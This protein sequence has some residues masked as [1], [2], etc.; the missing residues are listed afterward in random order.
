MKV[1]KI[2]L[3]LVF[4]ITIAAS[5][6]PLINAD[7]N[8]PADWN[9]KLFE[10][11]S[12][13]I[14]KA[15]D[16]KV[17]GMPCGGLFAG[18][19]Y[20]R[21]DG[22]LAYWWIANDAANTAWSNYKKA[23]HPLGTYEH[24]YGTYEPFSPIDQG[25]AIA[26]TSDH[27]KRNVYQLNHDGFDDIDFIA[28][29][30]IAKVMYK[31]K[32]DDLPCKIDCSIY[33]PFI[34]LNAKDSAIPVTL[35]N[36][37]LQNTSSEKIKIDL[38]GFLEN[39]VM[40]GLKTKIQ[41]K[42]RN[43]AISQD[44]LTSV[45]YDY[46]ESDIIAKDF[47]L[48]DGFEGWQIDADKW[49]IQGDCFTKPQRHQSPG[50]GTVSSFE[51]DFFIS[52][53]TG[54]EKYTGTM[55]SKE[56]TI[57]SDY[58]TFLIGGGKSD[59]L[60]IKLLVNGKAV[61]NSTGKKREYLHPDCWDVKQLKGKKARLVI[62]DNSSK[63]WGHINID[64][65]G[66]CNM[67]YDNFGNMDKTHPQ[68]GNMA[69]TCMDDDAI[70]IPA[71]KNID[72]LLELLRTDKIN[73]TNKKA[74]HM[75]G[76][77]SVGAVVS[78][79]ELTAGKTRELTFAISWYFPNRQQKIF[80]SAPGQLVGF[81]KPVGNMYRNF[82]KDSFDVASYVSKNYKRLSTDTFLFHDTYYN[83]T[84]LPRWFVDRIAMPVSTL[85]T[86]T[87][88]WWANGR[89]WAWEGVASCPGVCTHVWN[90]QHA[91][92]RL[93]PSVQRSVRK[94]QD[95]GCSLKD[96]GLIGDRGQVGGDNPENWAL[97][98]DGQAGTIMKAYR[99]HL[100]TEDNEFL[101]DLWPG[102]KLAMNYLIDGY[103]KTETSKPDGV[104]QGRQPNT[105]DRAI[106]GANTF[107][108]SYYLGALKAAMKMAEIVG[109]N[110]Y[111]N[112]LL[113]IY[114][115]GSRKTTQMLWN[116]QYFI[117]DVDLQKHKREQYGTGCLADQLI[118]QNWA[119]QVNLGYL[120]PTDKVR[121]TLKSIWNYNW[122]PNVGAYNKV[123]PARRIFAQGDEPGMFL[124]TWPLGN[125]P[126]K[127]VIYSEEIWTGS[128]YQVASHMIYEGMTK[129]GLSIIKG[130][131]QRYDGVKHNPF[132]EIEC[133]DH[134]SRAMASWGA[135]I[136]AERFIYDGPKATIGFDP[137]LMADD[138]N[139]FFSAAKGW[140]SLVQK[141]NSKHQTNS[142]ILKWG[143]LKCKK[144][145]FG[146]PETKLD[147]K[148]KVTIN[149]KE[150]KTD[151]TLQ[152]KKLTIVLPEQI[153]LKPG[154]ILK[155]EIVF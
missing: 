84:T 41:G 62:F 32:A 149:S 76:D 63:G 83:K 96:T 25:F 116:G 26:I 90:Y 108:G 106:Y 14:Y 54:R 132:N 124:I 91:L 67:P 87:C 109:D 94:M 153:T 52:S 6:K 71:V 135:L 39:A 18:Q 142:I 24:A 38:A 5:A 107:T 58:I 144:L 136:A 15:N 70:A 111:A 139:A 73:S 122:T 134:Y 152:N 101:K 92:A 56:F 150:I 151:F 35:F 133:G 140:G 131:A 9:Q 27:G 17:I 2:V 3:S 7:K 103:D 72:E 102:I 40:L 69:L 98:I 23:R 61:R 75:I 89:F 30:P 80:H 13:H 104:L 55:T 129:E 79:L 123:H 82:Y 64:Q 20:V 68:L 100:L 31:N 48:F 95:F 46:F 127:P 119:H 47:V 4:A 36:F 43:K 155:T 37:K 45:F 110:D 154:D 137:A 117:Q 118:G 28:E 85:A 120:Y 44:G 114:N 21:A 115:S 128:E 22:T 51:G 12:S 66:F 34:P 60:G 33:S 105:Y 16:S 130:I 147:G 49:T 141:R 19:L 77:G 8:L 59:D 113:P 88:Q 126:E 42:S 97:A 145:I 11:G 74:L 112:Y 121:Q 29:Y 143:L 86:E 138:F 81:G 125:K 93:F 50:Q 99:E 146:L 78:S 1:S 57:D 148:L 10:R 65:I 53:H